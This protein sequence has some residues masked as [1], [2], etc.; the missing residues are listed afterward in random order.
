[1]IYKNKKYIILIY[2][3]VKN[4][5]KNNHNYTLEY[6]IPTIKLNFSHVSKK[7]KSCKLRNFSKTVISRYLLSTKKGSKHQSNLLKKKIEI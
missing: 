5:L 4:I 6:L 3:Q 1:M 2:F 7:K